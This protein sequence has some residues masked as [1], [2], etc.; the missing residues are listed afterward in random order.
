[1]TIVENFSANLRM[2]KSYLHLD[3]LPGLIEDFTG[4]VWC[5]QDA[6]IYRAHDPEDIRSYLQEGSGVDIWSEDDE[7]I[8]EQNTPNLTFIT[9]ADNTLQVYLNKLRVA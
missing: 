4:F 3:E 8:K 9:L 6:T 5:I 7:V 1:M 2:A